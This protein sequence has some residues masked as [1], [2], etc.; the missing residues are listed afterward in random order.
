M[1][2]ALRIANIRNNDK[3]Y[4]LKIYI[5]FTEKEKFS[6]FINKSKFLQII[7]L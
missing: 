3:N 5:N 2:E 4:M 1:L 7:I 6:E